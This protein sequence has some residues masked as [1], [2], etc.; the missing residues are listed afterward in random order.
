MKLLCI[1]LL[2]LLPE[3][4]GQSGF[5]TLAGV[6]RTADGLPAANVRVAAV[7][8]DGRRPGDNALM[9]IVQTGSQ[10]TYRIENLPAGGY[11][12]LAGS[13]DTPDYYPGTTGAKG[14]A[15][16]TVA[17][18]LTTRVP[19]F[20][21]AP[22]SN[23]V[24][25]VRTAGLGSTGA[26]SGLVRDPQGKPLRNFTL[27]LW[28]SR[29]SARW[30]TVSDAGG[31]FAFSELPP[32]QF[33]LLILSPI[34]SGYNSQGYEQLQTSFVLGTGESLDEEI[35][36][37]LIVP[38]EARRQPTIYAP[39]PSRNSGTGSASISENAL[40]ARP[41]VVPAEGPVYPERARQSGLAASIAVQIVFDIDGNLRTARVVD[42]GVDS[43]LARSAV[44][45]LQRWRAGPITTTAGELLPLTA[46]VT[47]RFPY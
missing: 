36:L 44:E 17:A 10:G 45:W 21:Y 3:P 20:V 26:F 9:G 33:S 39:A 7:Q 18:G 13:L 22:W 27:M 19:D 14:P 46:T 32:G 38:T 29:T 31:L 16:V 6:L 25:A 1:F 37:R 8:A 23:I 40:W 5:G 34:R 35:Q 30:F 11:F 47:V 2:A 12:I 28:E 43:G 4:A 41:G 42:P 15:P 24:K